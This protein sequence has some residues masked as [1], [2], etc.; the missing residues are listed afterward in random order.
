MDP[1]P[2]GTPVIDPKYVPWLVLAGAILGPV[3]V[4][5]QDP[6]PWTTAKWG[7]LLAL[8]VPAVLG[9]LSP[10]LRRADGAKKALLVLLALGTV[11]L[12]MPAHAQVLVSAGPTLPLLELR[13]GNPHPVNLAA[14]A[15]VQV[16]FSLPQLQVEL[17]GRLW[18][19][20]DLQLLAFG[21]AVSTSS[22]ATFG[23]FS[24]AGGL[25]V[26]SSALCLAEGHDIATAVGMKPDWF[27]VFALSFNVDVNPTLA[28]AFGNAKWSPPR[29]NHVYIGGI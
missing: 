1:S 14:G 13:P 28:V 20:V 6:A 24:A 3:A 22:G 4:E 8:L 29:A 12:S 27:T 11:G 9:I 19:L 15:G 25:C 5:L 7:K 10:G 26:F 23:A 2:T 21:T 16:S 17:G 18:D